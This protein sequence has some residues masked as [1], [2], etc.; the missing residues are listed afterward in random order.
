MEHMVDEGVGGMPV[1]DPSLVG[2]VT[3]DMSDDRI[4]SV[5]P[6]TPGPVPEVFS[7]AVD[8]DLA[9][10]QSAA[11]L[12]QSGMPEIETPSPGVVRLPGGFLDPNG[13]LHQ[14]AEVRELRG[15]DEERLARIDPEENLPLWLTTLLDCGVVALGGVKPSPEM[16]RLL[17][18]GDRE[19]II[20][21]IRIAT[22]GNE[23]PMTVRC[24]NCGHEEAVGIELDK[25][26]PVKTME[27]PL[28]REFPVVLKD[29]STAVI[30]LPNVGVQDDVMAATKSTVAD[31]TNLTLSRCLSTIN[32][33]PVTLEQ[34][35]DL[36]LQDRKTLMKFINEQQPGPD[37]GGVRLPCEKCG[38]PMSVFLS[39]ADLFR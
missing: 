32:G 11:F 34:V 18:I 37:Y 19:Q 23:V 25:D 14:H 8:P 21:G 17:L 3:L 26:V 35:R 38:R 22:Y 6:G 1:H 16:L 2:E 15:R 30:G 33:R 4:P 36:G 27:N 31:D 28:E 20:L 7:T 10:A 12:S 13:V 29:G 39:L 9:S 5:I 24:P